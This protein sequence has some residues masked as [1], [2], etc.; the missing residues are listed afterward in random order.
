MRSLLQRLAEEEG[1][2]VRHI[3][4][5]LKNGRIVLIKNKKHRIKPLLIGEG[6]RVKINANIGTSP[7]ISSL[8]YELKKLKAA[9]DAG[10]DTVMDLSTGGNINRI[11]KEIIN[12]SGVPV[13]T[14]PIYQVA[15]DARKKRRSFLDASVDEIFDVIEQHLDDG[16]DFITVHCGV[17]RESIRGLKRKKRVCGIVSRGGSMMVEWMAY[18]KRENPLYEYYDR[19]L[20]LAKKYNAT[21]SLGDGL[22]PGAI[23]DATDRYQIKE[24][25]VIGELVRWAR[26]EDVSVMVEGP[27][28]VP[29]NEIEANIR[30]EKTIC[31][32][33]PFYVLGPLVTDVGA[34]Y[35]HIVSA[36][37]GALA[38]YYGADYL[39]YVTPSEHLGLPDV[40]EVRE[41]VIAARLAAHAA[42]I[43]RGNS[44]AKKR[45]L[46][47]SRARYALDWRQMLNLLIDKK[48]AEKIFKRSPSKSNM[49]CT[50]CG[51]FCAMK[52]TKEVIG[53]S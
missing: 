4:K 1:V 21:L 47:L 33:A 46:E 17:T 40:D 19:L 28:H 18:N 32:G 31:E 49:T 48:K 6:L 20:K 24:L 51:E 9:V 12:A 23:A 42:D 37:G 41:G 43:A 38:A 13:G 8:K 53:R 52:K 36:I 5:G 30:L 34:G 27:G 7:D 22:R 25:I 35:D 16:V 44:K 10:A 45:D 14:V 11:R 39:C 50:M 29:I 3:G 15:I 2:S 26:D